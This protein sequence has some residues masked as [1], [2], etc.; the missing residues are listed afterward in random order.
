MKKTSYASEVVFFFF[1]FFISIDFR[2][3]FIY[4]FIY[5]FHDIFPNNFVTFPERLG[6][7]FFRLIYLFIYF[8]IASQ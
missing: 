4:L 6:F 5:L 7:E 3:I 1:F 2:F 8:D